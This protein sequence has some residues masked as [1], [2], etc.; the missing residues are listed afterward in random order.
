MT[1]QALWT[2]TKLG[3]IHLP[4]RLAM[5]PMTRSRAAGDGTITDLTAQY[6]GQRSTFSL[7]ITEGTQPSGDGQGY[8]ATP[9]IYESAHVEAW[10]SAADAAHAGGAAFVIQLMHVGRV[11][12]PSNTPHGRRPVAPS[13]VAADAMMFTA[14][15][16]QPMADPVPL[17]DAGLEQTLEDFRRAAAL[18]IEAGADGVEIHG[19]NGYLL[20]QFLS[21]NA[22]LRDD[23]YGGSIV[24]RARFP[25]EV[26]AAVADEIGADRT[27]FRISPANRLNDIK[28]VDTHALYDHLARGLAEIDL[29]YLHLV[30]IGDEPLLRR[31]RAIWPDRLVVN[32]AGA[33]LDARIADLDNG[34]ADVV[35]VGALALANPDLPARIQASAPL[36]SPDPATFYGGD[37]R[38]YTDYPALAV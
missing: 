29:A 8:L 16:P 34:L 22:N 17:D 7:L 24:G 25:L 9:G 20:H 23:R 10:R 12:H 33:D 26:A 14:D 2:P 11:A 35:A 31:L 30:H 27:G 32:R 21:A 15:G 37:H 36:N 6:Y 38:G 1:D 4:H 13:T 28:E 19:A 5:A 18:A 3:S